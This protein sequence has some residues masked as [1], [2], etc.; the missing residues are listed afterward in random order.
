MIILI[1]TLIL[2][3]GSLQLSSTSWREMPSMYSCKL[4]QQMV[5]NAIHVD[6]AEIHTVCARVDPDHWK[7]EP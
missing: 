3:G 1:V 7:K 5:N 2:H 6:G 4:T